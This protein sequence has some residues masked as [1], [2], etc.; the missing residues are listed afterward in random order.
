MYAYV[1]YLLNFNYFK[2]F[3]D[4]ALLFLFLL[5]KTSVNTLNISRKLTK[6][7]Y[8][9]WYMNFTILLF[10]KLLVYYKNFYWKK[11]M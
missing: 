11:I 3:L 7:K 9:T 10:Y 1:Q 8:F 4:I 6:I 5:V 2:I